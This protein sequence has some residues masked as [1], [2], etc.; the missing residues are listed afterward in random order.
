MAASVFDTSAFTRNLDG[1]D[2]SP[3]LAERCHAE[4]MALVAHSPLGGHRRADRAGRERAL[5]AIAEARR[6]AGADVSPWQVALAWL[7]GMG[8]GVIPIP[9]A[10][11]TDR[12]QA[13]ARAA[14]LRLTAEELQQIEQG[15]R[16]QAPE[17]R[18][19]VWQVNRPPNRAVLLMGPPA[20]GKTS[21][22]DAYVAR[23]YRRLNRD[24]AG[25]S[26]AD[27]H[28][29]MA[30]QAD[31]GTRAFV[32]DNTY[33]T[34]ESRRGA[35]EIAAKHGLDTLGIHLDVPLGE[36]LMNA[37]FRMM[38]RHGRILSPDEIQTLSKQDPNM[39]PPAA[40]YHFYNQWQ[41]PTEAEGFRRIETA[42][43]VRRKNANQVHRALLL[44]VDGTLR[45]TRSGALFPSDPDD[46]VLL[47]GRKEVLDRHLADGWKLLGI[48]NQS[49]IGKGR[50]T[51]DAVR[52][53]FDRTEELL[54][55]ELDILYS[56]H[57]ATSAGVWSRKP[58]PGMVVEHIVRHDLDRDQCLV[59]GDL[60]S[61]RELAELCGIEFRWAE[62]FFDQPP[63]T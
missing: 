39:L 52:R 57:P 16:A 14:A 13:N 25:G 17:Q 3:S 23:G 56:P 22:V 40:I 36:A 20:A 4:G 34:R 18:R 28:R 26:I 55:R 19:R 24:Q 38:E 46:V 61:D 12:I 62:E 9:G 33:P 6:Q 30:R 27:L 37:C 10:T 59:V 41:A 5:V 47:P 21:R 11:K 7:L 35:L 15:K 44:D 43:F 42:P 2:G 63:L 32:L 58:M 8:P 60:D 31:D 51:D 1:T 53:C 50:V 49:A 45:K 48:S 54:G 29:E